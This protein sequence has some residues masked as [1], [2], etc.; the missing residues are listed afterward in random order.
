MICG[1]QDERKL[2]F[3]VVKTGGKQYK[4]SEGDVIV[5]ERLA[6][7]AGDNVTLDH[8]LMMGT[9][10]KLEV[11]TPTIKG[12]VVTAEILEQARGD[13][14]IVFKKKRRHNYRRK[15]GHRQDLTVLRILGIGADGKKAAPKKAAATADK[16]KA[17]GSKAVDKDEAV[18]AAAPKATAAKKTTETKSKAAASEKKPAAKK[19]PAKKAAPKKAES[20]KTAPKKTAAKKA[21]PKKAE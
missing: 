11:G 19:A 8:V 15:R 7:E 14:I 18:K 12:G 4:V 13:K 17:S 3:A 20:A 9:D 2:M 5:I 16:E 21:A 1:V 10:K 6:G